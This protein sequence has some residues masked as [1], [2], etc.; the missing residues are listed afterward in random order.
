MELLQLERRVADL[1]RWKEEMDRERLFYP[2]DIESREI[3]NKSLIVFE[4]DNNFAIETF[5]TDLNCFGL[6]VSINGQLRSLFAAYPL[7]EFTA[8]DTTNI[9]TAVNGQHGLSNGTVV[10]FSST[11]ILPD[12]LD[13]ITQYY[14]ISSTATTF[15][16]STSLGGS[17][18]DILD[19]G[20]GTHYFS[21]A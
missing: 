6:E 15:K 12:G 19:T 18:V 14:V 1:R 2:L 11:G 21:I 8:S 13:T 16:V 9:I 20:T 5:A 10:V 3:K 17:E 4:K 7:F